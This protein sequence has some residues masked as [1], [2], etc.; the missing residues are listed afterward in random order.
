M[1]LNRRRVKLVSQLLQN[2]ALSGYLLHLLTTG[3]RAYSTIDV[4]IGACK[5]LGVDIV[6]VV[7]GTSY[8]P[9]RYKNQRSENSTQCLKYIENWHLEE[10][11][12]ALKELLE[13]SVTRKK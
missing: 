7:L 9:K 8:V 10:N 6:D 2:K 13:A 11:R 1:Q 5:E 12:R 3:N 4:L